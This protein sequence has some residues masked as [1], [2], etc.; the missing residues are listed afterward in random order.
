MDDRQHRHESA[1]EHNSTVDTKITKLAKGRNI[2]AQVLIPVGLLIPKIKEVD[3]VNM[4]D[5]MG[6]KQITAQN[7]TKRSGGAPQ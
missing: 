2:K 1:L 3:L 4:L 6:S 7:H 5:V